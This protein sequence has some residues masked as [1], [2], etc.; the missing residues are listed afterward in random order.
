VSRPLR[1]RC[2][3][4]SRNQHRFELIPALRVLALL[5]ALLFLP[6]RAAES[7]PPKPDR[8]FNDYTGTVRAPAARAFNEQLADHERAT[9][10]QILVV[11]FPR[12]PDGAALEDFTVRT[13]HAWAVGQKGRNNGAVLFVFK[14]DRKLYL[15]VG[16][17]LEGVLPDALAKRIIENEITP[18]F[19][20]NNFEGG[21]GAG[22][23]AILAATRGEYKGTGRTVA[24]RRRGQDSPL[25]F[26]I[27]AG[28]MLVIFIV[29]GRRARSGTV[30][31]R[32]GRAYANPLPMPWFGGGGFGSGSSGGGS[33]DS[34]SSY[35]GGGGDSGGGG[36]GG[37]W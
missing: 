18:N 21:I 28:V 1:V 6:A 9:S 30:Y 8:Y 37:S 15:Q 5:S 2:P 33:S 29:A 19:R 32:S 20:R 35:S 25:M 24:D 11:V 26:F 16:Y 7:L 4:F 23:A 31:S 13:F 14:D 27:V 12:L 17:G 10:N 36:A 3:G 34:G 22:I